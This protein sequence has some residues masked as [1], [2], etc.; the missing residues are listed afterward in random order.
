M[1]YSIDR[2]DKAEEYTCTH[3]V[4]PRT[5]PFHPV[6]LATADCLCFNGTF[7]LPPLCAS[8][9]HLRFPAGL[10]FKSHHCRQC[11]ISQTPS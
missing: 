8:A 9:Y 11:P 1:S 4:R 10:G 7:D 3:M 6:P 2:R 5:S